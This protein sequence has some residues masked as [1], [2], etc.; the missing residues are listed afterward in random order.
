[1]ER[2]HEFEREQGGYK[3]GVAGRKG[4]GVCDIIIISIK[5]A[6]RSHLK[7]WQYVHLYLFANHSFYVRDAWGLL[8]GLNPLVLVLGRIAEKRLL[9]RWNERQ[10]VCSHRL[11]ATWQRTQVRPSQGWSLRMESS[12]QTSFL[13]LGPGT[14]NG[15]VSLTLGRKSM[16]FVMTAPRYEY[17]AFWEKIK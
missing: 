12:S 3:R 10:D 5:E 17:R 16:V 6:I 2:S 4:K 14:G 9:R 7:L 11:E 8:L 13:R 1:M 15:C